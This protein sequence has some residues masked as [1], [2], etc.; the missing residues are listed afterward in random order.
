MRRVRNLLLNWEGGSDLP[1]EVSFAII[2]ADVQ[3]SGLMCFER[4]DSMTTVL[5]S[6]DSLGSYE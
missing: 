2:N 1:P 3:D 5:I 6:L 4:F